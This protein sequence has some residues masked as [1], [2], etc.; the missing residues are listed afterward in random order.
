MAPEKGRKCQVCGGVVKR[1]T[2]SIPWGPIDYCNICQSC[3][4]VVHISC[5]WELKD[6]RVAGDFWLCEC[7]TRNKIYSCD[8][9]MTED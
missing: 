4:K 7:G 8:D 9:W 6:T 2:K 5:A 1:M 3:G